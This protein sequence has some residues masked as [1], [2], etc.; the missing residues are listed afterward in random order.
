MQHG[1]C[2]WRVGV[3]PPMDE[4]ELAALGPMRDAVMAK[5]TVAAVMEIEASLDTDA[6]RAVG[7]GAHDMLPAGST[8]AAAAGRTPD[9]CGPGGPAL[10]SV[11]ATTDGM[12]AGSPAN[13]PWLK[14][15]AGNSGAGGLPGP[16]A[17]VGGSAQRRLSI[18]APKA[19]RSSWVAVEAPG[20]GIMVVSGTSRPAATRRASSVMSQHYPAGMGGMGAGA[21]AAVGASPSALEGGAAPDEAGA[22]GNVGGLMTP[23]YDA[24][25]FATR[26]QPRAVRMQ[27]SSANGGHAPGLTAEGAGAAG[28]GSGGAGGGAQGGRESSTRESAGD[29]CPRG[30]G[31]EASALLETLAPPAY[32]RTVGSSSSAGSMGNPRGA[33]MDAPGAG[34]AAEST[35]ARSSTPTPRPFTPDAPPE[36]LKLPSTALQQEWLPEESVPADGQTASRSQPGPL[37]ES[38]EQSSGGLGR[39]PTYPASLGSAAARALF[40]PNSTSTLNINPEELLLGSIMTAR[41]AQQGPGA[42]PLLPGGG[43]QVDSSMLLSRMTPSP[44]STETG[45]GHKGRRLG[46]RGSGHG[47]SGPAS[48]TGVQQGQQHQGQAGDDQLADADDEARV[49]VLRVS[50]WRTDLMTTVAEVDGNNTIISFVGD[51]VV[52]PGGFTLAWEAHAACTWCADVKGASTNM[53]Y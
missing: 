14:P 40:R 34:G 25:R 49:V 6:I 37:G 3:T 17:P 13:A 47:M 18:I 2:S 53:G 20:G 28:S 5:R 31:P 23:D 52:P 44:G 41:N 27:Q 10:G 4:V 36:T 19:R 9:A 42:G 24:I 32:R 22:V 16:P 29:M 43:A 26:R 1:G 50:L 46:V 8:A 48:Q 7:G 38:V 51:E 11:P 39:P 33:H 35:A 15:T 21:V 12:G 45:M 30:L